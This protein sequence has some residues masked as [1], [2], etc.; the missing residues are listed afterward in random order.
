M[1]IIEKKEGS[2]VSGREI[3]ALV[4]RSSG[5]REFEERVKGVV[6]GGVMPVRVAQRPP[7][8]IPL[9]AGVPVAPSSVT[10]SGPSGRCLGGPAAPPAG[11]PPLP[12]SLQSLGGGVSNANS[13]AGAA[14]NG[15]SNGNTGN[16]GTLVGSNTGQGGI[17]TQ[18]LGGVTTTSGVTTN[19]L[20]AMASAAASLTQLNNMANGPLPPLAATGPTGPP[21]LPPPQPATTPTHGGP[22]TPHA[23]VTAGP[24]LNGASPSPHPM[25]P[26]GMMS[27]SPHAPHPHMGGGGPS[28]HPHHPGPHMVGSPHHPGPH[29]MGPAAGM[30]GP[31]GMQPQA[32]PGMCGPGPTGP[33]GPHAHPQGPGVPG[34]PHMHNDPFYCSPFGSH[35]F[36]RHTPYFGQPDYRLYELNKRLQQRTE[37]SDNLWWDAFATEFFE[38]DATLTLTFCLE[39]GPKRYTIG[40]TLIPRYFRSIFEGGV[41]ELYYNLK[42]PKESF[43]NT[44]ITLDCDNCVMVT[45]HGKPMFTKVCTEGRLILEFTF[46]DL[47]RIKSWHMSVRTHKELVPRTVVGMQQDPT[48]LEQ[49]SKNI[50]RQGITNST[51]NYLRLCVILEPMQELMSRHKAYALSPRD[52]LKTTLFQKWQRMVAPPES[53]RPAS[54][55][56]KRK[57]S[58]SG[59]GNNAPPAPSKKRSPGP[60]FSLASQDVMVVG[61][62]SL[63][64]GDFGEEDERVITRLENT[65]YDA[66]NSLDPHSHDTPGGPPPH[67][68]QFHSEPTPG[69]SWPPDR[70]P[71]PPQGGPG[72]QGVQGGQGGAAAGVQGTQDASQ[73]QQDKK[74]PAVSQ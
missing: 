62:P 21:S 24:H 35:Y 15:S 44:S 5:R 39:D 9:H 33:M 6:E 73:Q 40:R 2:K 29:P 56:R 17:A 23:G 64:G 65:Q 13:A 22:P 38:D 59:P 28:P 30:M 68:H 7:G 49:L 72:S 37:E 51:L 48:M 4:P 8:G 18:A 31:A 69:N 3:P 34:Q 45:H 55:R 58:T 26:H 47:M 41:T 1:A 12:P 61:E 60:N 50:T 67:P 32:A 42:H 43:H 57:G 66:T 52:C 70:G 25:P 36:R 53:Q 16:T 63:M 74:S 27:G 10:A 71:G 14:S 46:D 11:S 54:K 19:P 20:Q